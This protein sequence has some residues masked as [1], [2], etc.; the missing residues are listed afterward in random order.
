VNGVL[1]NSVAAV[2]G[3]FLPQLPTY[4]EIGSAGASGG[5]GMT[6]VIWA[7]IGQS[8]VYNR[9]LSATEVLQNYNDVKGRYGL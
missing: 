2:T 1:N 8:L 3:V 9:A 5:G 6:F 4:I 7:Q